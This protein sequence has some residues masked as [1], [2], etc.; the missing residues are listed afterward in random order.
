VRLHDGG[1]RLDVAHWPCQIDS[2]D[3]VPHVE[4]KIVEVGEGDRFVVSGVVDE[5]IQTAE[6]LGHVAD[7]SL[8]G[9]IIGYSHANAAALI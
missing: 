3:L 2:H 6:A 9:R 4:R 1:R 5:D 8:Y 7:Q